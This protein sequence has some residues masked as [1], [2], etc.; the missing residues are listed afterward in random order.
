MILYEFIRLVL[1]YLL[2][3]CHDMIATLIVWLHQAA[4]TKQNLDAARNKNVELT[5]QIED[6]MQKLKDVKKFLLTEWFSFWILVSNYETCNLFGIV[7]CDCQ[8]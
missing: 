3:L 6:Y 7:M 4:Q 5:E 1:M 8:T 2:W